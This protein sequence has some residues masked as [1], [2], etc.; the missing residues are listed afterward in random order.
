MAISLT[1]YKEQLIEQ[2]T[3][4]LWREWSALGVAGHASTNAPWIIDPEALLLFSTVVARHDARLFDEILDWLHTNDSWISLQ[5]LGTMIKEDQLGDMSVLAAMSECLAKDA[6]HQKWKMIIKKAGTSGSVTNQVVE[7]LFPGLPVT[8]EADPIFLERSLRRGAIHLRGMS[9][10]PRPNQ[11]ATFLFKLRALFGRQARAEVMAWLLANGKGHPAEIARQTGY[12]RR[13]VQIVLNELSESGHVRAIRTGREK[14]F[15][16][17]SDE[18]RFL[19]TW[20]DAKEFPQWIA[21]APVFKVI[22]TFLETLS[23]PDLDEHSERFQAIQ[24]REAL[25][26]ALPSLQRAGLVTKFRSSPDMN[27]RALI[28]SIMADIKNILD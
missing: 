26:S 23:M 14:D 19:M 15:I 3:R 12:F 22:L 28:E 11:P 17:D 24:F 2:L 27:G 20:E 1:N 7:R 18:W 5:R 21:W 8:G 16:I 25:D 13:T 10:S 9:R 4:F 6:T